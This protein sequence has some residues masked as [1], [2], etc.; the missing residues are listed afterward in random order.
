M[1]TP[2]DSDV[3]GQIKVDYRNRR[4]PFAYSAVGAFELVSHYDVRNIKTT[5]A[6]EAMRKLGLRDVLCQGNSR[7]RLFVTDPTLAEARPAEVMAAYRRERGLPAVAP[8]DPKPIQAKPSPS[9]RAAS[10]AKW[11]TIRATLTADI[12]ARSGPFRLDVLTVADVMEF[13]GEGFE[14]QDR[15]SAMLR[16]LTRRTALAQVKDRTKARLNTV[17]TTLYVVADDPELLAMKPRELLVLYRQARSLP[18]A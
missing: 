9:E 18:E 1:L 12:A 10:S 2:I 13:Y 6:T 16:E 14:P 8:V 7:I 4:G 17:Q 5:Q 11:A 15:V 3:F